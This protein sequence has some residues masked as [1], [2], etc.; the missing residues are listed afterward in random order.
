MA[1]ICKWKVFE[2]LEFKKRKKRKIH[3]A[4]KKDAGGDEKLLFF[5][6]WPNILTTALR[7]SGKCLI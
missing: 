4:G 1:E 6:T 2:R 3:S 5:F 7:I